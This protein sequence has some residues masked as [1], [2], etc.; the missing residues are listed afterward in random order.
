MGGDLP[1]PSQAPHRVL[2]ILGM[3]VPAAKLLSCWGESSQRDPILVSPPVWDMC[4]WEGVWM[5]QESLGEA[6]A[7]SGEF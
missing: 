7:G 6:A 3:N 2:I 4:Q 5:W 1:A